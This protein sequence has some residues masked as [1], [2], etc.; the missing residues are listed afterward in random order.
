[1]TLK[2][3]NIAVLIIAII[4]ALLLWRHGPAVSGA[5]DAMNQLG[6]HNATEDRLAGFMVLG[7]IGVC[8]V[9]IVKI[10]THNRPHDRRGPRDDPP[11]D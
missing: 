4:I 2:P 7:L 11:E 8:I 3:H 10:L 9:A 6:P 5:L 1:M